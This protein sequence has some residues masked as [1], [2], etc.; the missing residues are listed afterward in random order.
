VS[1]SFGIAAPSW[2]S[3]CTLR[4]GTLARG[5]KKESNL[6]AL[7]RASGSAS[8]CTDARPALRVTLRADVRRDAS[9]VL[10]ASS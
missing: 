3:G 8:E 6:R 5:F 1:V 10:N 2:R 7:A 4:A 9:F